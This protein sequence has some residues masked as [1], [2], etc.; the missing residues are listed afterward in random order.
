M[1]KIAKLN[2]FYP[3]FMFKFPDSY[4]RKHFSVSDRADFFKK[5]IRTF[6]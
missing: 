6:G 1:F 5:A 4:V 3:P 2:Q